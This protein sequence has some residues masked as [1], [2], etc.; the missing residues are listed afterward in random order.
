M[1]FAFIIPAPLEPPGGPLNIPA[2]ALH[3]A[4]P[5]IVTETTGSLFNTSRAAGHPHIQGT[6]TKYSSP[7]LKKQ[8]FPGTTSDVLI[9]RLCVLLS[10][11]LLD[12]QHPH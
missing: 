2:L 8:D 1:I 6:Y 4:K 3:T 12:T 11:G 10:D 7:F 9:R 5:E